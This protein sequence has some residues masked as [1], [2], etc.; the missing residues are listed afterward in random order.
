MRVSVLLLRFRESQR[1][2]RHK[3]S[4]HRETCSA[5]SEARFLSDSFAGS[6]EG[7]ET[8]RMTPKS[9]ISSGGIFFSVRILWVIVCAIVHV[10]FV[11]RWFS[12]PIPHR[13]GHLPL[14]VP[15]SALAPLKYSPTYL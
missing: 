12:A 13:S 7:L 11:H 14:P 6:N 8:Y 2:I 9:G 15:L 5:Q 4:D 1:L 3:L 10:S